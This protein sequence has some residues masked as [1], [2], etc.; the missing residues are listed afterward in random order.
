VAVLAERRARRIEDARTFE[1]EVPGDELRE[2]AIELAQRL[3][4]QVREDAI[5][6]PMLPAAATRVLAIANDPSASVQEVAR[7]VEGDPLLAARILAVANSARYGTTRVGSL[8]NALARLGSGTVRDV[9]YEA[10][11]QAHIF[12]GPAGSGLAAELEHAVGVARIAQVVCERLGIP[13]EHAFVCGLLHDIGRP[14]IVGIVTK[15]REPPAEMLRLVDAAH[16]R[17]GAEVAKRW[18]LP[19]VVADVCLQHHHDASHSQFA[20]IVT[21]ADRIARHLG[22]GRRVTAIDLSRDRCFFDLGLDRDRVM[23]LV[24]ATAE[25]DLRVAA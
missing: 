3:V 7:V 9:L 1:I 8:K 4:K 6:V 17:V 2:R 16:A 5:A 23:E 13:S 14:I 22:I 12:R 15:M 18:A 24:R 25:L 10:V 21:V 19:K 20:S 11:A